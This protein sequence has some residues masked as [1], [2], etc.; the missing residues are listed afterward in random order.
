MVV[1]VSCEA[2]RTDA[3][4]RSRRVAISNAADAARDARLTH[5]G[6]R[7]RARLACRP[8][9]IRSALEALINFVCCTSTTT[10]HDGQTHVGGHATAPLVAQVAVSTEAAYCRA[11]GVHAPDMITPI[12][13]RLHAR[14]A[15]VH[16]LLVL[17]AR[18]GGC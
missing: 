11:T 7:T 3:L 10:S 17:A 14:L 16:E 6:T 9:L 5:V 2:G 13:A 15:R 1:F 4:G 8:H 18:P 12:R